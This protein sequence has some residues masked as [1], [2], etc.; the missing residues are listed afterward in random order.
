MKNE[1]ILVLDF[2][3]QYKELIASRVRELSVYSEIRPGSISAE[4]I[5]TI[6]PIG[7]ILTGGPKS[8][9]GEDAPKCDSEIFS[10]GIPVL[11]I[12]YGMQLMCHTLGG[13][14]GPGLGG[15]EYGRVRTRLNT[16]H[17]LFGGMN[18]RSM[19]LMSHGDMVIKLPEG[20]VKTASTAKCPIAGGADE[21]HGLYAVQFHPEVKHTD[22]GTEL[23]RHFLFEVCMAK[24][25][26]NIDDYLEAAAAEIRRKA[27]ND[28]ILLALSGGVDSS[29]C[30]AL[31]EKAV[32]GKLTCVFVDHGLMR[33]NEGDS[34]EAIF[35][36]RQLDFIRVNAADRFLSAL[37]GADEPEQKRKIIG[38]EFVEVFQE[39]AK[40]LGDIPFLAQGTIYPDIVESGGG[41]TATIKS[42]HNVGG[43]PENIGFDGLIEPLR[44]LFKDEVRA[45]GRKLGLPDALVDRQP[46]PG[47]GLAVRVLGEVTPEKLA[48]LREADS[49]VREEIGM[50]KNPPSQYFAVLPGVRTVGVAGDE[51]RYDEIIAVRAVITSDFMTAEYAPLPHS[52]LSRISARIASEVPGAGRV[53][54]DISGKPPATIEWE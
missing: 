22:K 48:L 8:V 18:E 20:F 27:G 19:T 43:L 39:E 33:K 54:Y 46:F 32:P 31:I 23:L 24:G 12:C 30:A 9:Y 17:K 11:G 51:R 15:G 42:H 36:E 14:V 13:K 4:E 2:G 21:A 25:D 16:A 7:L 5:R 40:K 44:G 47:P 3:G 45:L 53:L 38:R 37:K 49:I 10:L 34:I 6:A 35:S 29:V 52:L 1:T 50:M 28:R 26:Y 41:V